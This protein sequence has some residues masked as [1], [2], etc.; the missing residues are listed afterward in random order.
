MKYKRILL[1]ILFLAAYT[2][3]AEPE[4]KR[5]F[6]VHEWGV[7]RVNTDAEYANAELRVEWDELPPFVYGHIKGRTV[8]QSWGAVEIRKRPIVFFHTDKPVI[9]KVHIDFPGGEAGAWYPATSVPSIIRF[10]KEP[11]TGQVLEWNLGIKNPP[12]GWAPGHNGLRDV[13]DKHWIQRIRQVSSDPIY[14]RFGPRF[15][16]VDFEKFLYYDG[17]FPQKNWVKI[18]IEAEKITLKNLCQHTLFDVTIVDRRGEPLRIAHVPEFKA[19]ASLNIDKW[20]KQEEATVVKESVARLQEQLVA[21]GLYQD[22]ADSM[23]DL[24]R[25]DF[26]MTPGLSLFYRLPQKEYDRCLPLTITPK[27]DS[28][29]R[30]GLIHQA[31]LEPEFKD[32]IIQLII[33]LDAKR[34]AERVEA[35][36]QLLR[37]GPAALAIINTYRK[38]NKISAEVENQLADLIKKWSSKDAFDR[39]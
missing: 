19:D 15:N 5:G 18:K 14:A 31:H 21:A 30:V 35:R 10:D 33:Q 34:F 37:C 38:T 1:C 11:K 2:A 3:G 17:I 29:V 22:E 32:K 23:I 27:P 6:A 39:D 25:T 36:K 24:W 9:A 12:Q 28:L 26:F 7:F 4:P 20:T 8:P 16:D 13:P